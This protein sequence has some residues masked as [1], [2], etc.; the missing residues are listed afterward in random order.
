MTKEEKQERESEYKTRKIEELTIENAE[1]DK[2]IVE[3]K[4]ENEKLK[5][6]ISA[7]EIDQSQFEELEKQLAIYK[8]AL[9]TACEYVQFDRDGCKHYHK[10]QDAEMSASDYCSKFA[11]KRFVKQ[12]KAELEEQDK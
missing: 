5:D 10:C 1:K 12:A 11:K 9:E 7:L 4:A 8:R 2:Q 3:L 6:R